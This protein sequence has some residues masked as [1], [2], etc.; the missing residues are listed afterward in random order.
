MTPTLDDLHDLRAELLCAD[1]QRLTAEEAL[2][3]ARLHERAA[4]ILR[5]LA[6]ERGGRTL[7]L[8][9]RGNPW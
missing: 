3:L 2:D 9:Q 8:R 4:A 6:S 1:P 7:D 5:D